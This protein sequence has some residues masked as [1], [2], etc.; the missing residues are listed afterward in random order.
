MINLDEFKIETKRL[1]LVPIN[2]I[3]QNDIFKEFSLEVARFL[4]PQPTGNI[5]NTIYFINDSREKTSQGSQ[6]QLVALNKDTKEFLACVGLHEINTKTPELGLWFKK[7]AWGLGYGK[8]SM[9][10]LKQ[11]ADKNLDYDY[12]N[13]P[14]YK[15]N[16]PSRKIAEFL[17]GEV[18]EE[19]KS[20]NQNGVEFD[21]VRYSIKSNPN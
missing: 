20:K 9:L 14:V 4:T 2:L 15:E 19:L 18:S 17:G 11:W 6:I 16:T 1:L 5:E 12:I 21:E 8:E 3:Y 13:Y 10:A 7:S